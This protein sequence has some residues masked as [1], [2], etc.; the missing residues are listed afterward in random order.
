MEAE[1][2]EVQRATSPESGEPVEIRVGAC[3]ARDRDQQAHVC[4]RCIKKRF[5]ERALGSS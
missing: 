3:G 4:H 1:P 5:D 2:R